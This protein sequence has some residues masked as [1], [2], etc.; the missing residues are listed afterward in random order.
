[1]PEKSKDKDRVCFVIGPIGEEGTEIRKR[2]DQLFNHVI[3]PTVAELGYSA[4]RADRLPRSSIITNDIINLLTDSELVIADLTGRNENVYYELA[5]RHGLRKP[6][7][8]I[9]EEPVHLPFDVQGVRAIGININDLDSVDSAKKK[10]KQYIQSIESGG[11][12]IEN[13]ISVAFD[14]QR[15]RKSGDVADRTRAEVIEGMSDLRRRLERIEQVLMAGRD[16]R[17]LAYLASSGM[18]PSP[19][20]SSSTYGVAEIFDALGKRRKDQPTIRELF[21]S[22]LESRVGPDTPDVE[23]YRK[24][25]INILRR[26]DVN[27]LKKGDEKQEEKDNDDGNGK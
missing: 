5:I 1:M 18:A 15:L 7:I 21:G 25:L 27:D 16:P 14:L 23:A 9:C 26:G 17:S 22:G 10:L 19:I 11:E 3:E 20:S 2:A 24:A 6:F 12:P 8:H 4:K 13:P